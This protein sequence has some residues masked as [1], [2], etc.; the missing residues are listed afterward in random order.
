MS[1]CTFITSIGGTLLS[2]GIASSMAH[3]SDLSA[4]STQPI[5]ETGLST[6]LGSLLAIALLSQFWIIVKLL[7]TNRLLKTSKANLASNQ[8]YLATLLDSI[9]EGVIA[10]DLQ[11]H[12]TLINPAAEILTATAS[13]QALGTPLTDIFTL[14]DT[15]TRSPIPNPVETLQESQS[16]Q[17]L[18]P[19]IL[20]VS[21]NGKEHHITCSTAPIMNAEGA[22]QGTI[23]SFSDCTEK[24]CA[25]QALKESEHHLENLIRNLPGM[26]Y[27]SRNTPE[28]PM[29]F[30]SAGALDLTGYPPEAF[31]PA[32]E[33]KYFTLIHP[34]DRDQVWNEIQTAIQNETLFTLVYRLIDADHSEKWVW[35]Q[36]AAIPSDAP[37]NK[38]IEGFITDITLPKKTQD[39][40]N[41]SEERFKQLAD[42]LPEIIFETDL[43]GR[44]TF[45]NQI[46]FSMTGYTQEEFDKGLYAFDLVHP[47]D[48]ERARKNLK[49][50]F[51]TGPIG[52]TEY[53]LITKNGEEFH[54]MFHTLP[55]LSNGKPV[56]TRGY[57]ID[58]SSR[59]CT[60]KALQDERE[61]L[62]Q[63]FEYM[64]NGVAVYEPI[65]DANDFI[66]VDINKAGEHI[67]RVRK[68]AILGKRLTEVFPAAVEHGL[69]GALKR[70]NET[71]QPQY[72]PFS[73]YR[74]TRITQHI[75]NR[76]FRL[77][78]GR[79]VSLF[80]DRTQQRQLEDRLQ[81]MEKMDAVGQLAG[82]IAHDFNNQLGVILGYADM[83]SEV[84][85]DPVQNRYLSNIINCA[86][87]SADLTRKLLAFARKGKFQFVP[88]NLHT[89][90]QDVSDI[91]RHS[92]D[93]RITIKQHLSADHFYTQGDPS[94]LQNALL[95]LA[96]NARDAMPEG[97]S[98][99]FT[100]ANIQ[101]ES[102]HFESLHFE[103]E[104]GNYVMITVMDT[105][106]GIP[107]NYLKHIF[108]P[109]F[110]TKETGKGS[111]MGL[112]AVYGTIK[113]HKGAIDVIS[114][115]GQGTTFSLY[116]P[117]T[118]PDAPPTQLTEK[119]IPAQITAK[120][121][122]IE[123][124]KS[125]R[126]MLNDML[127]S[128]NC[129]AIFCD[130]GKQGIEEYRQNWQSIDLV[131]L[132]MVM[133]GMNGTETFRELVQINPDITIL[134]ISGYSVDGAAQQLLNEG[135]A[136]FIQKPFDK[137]Q[138]LEEIHRILNQKMER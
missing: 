51:E 48:R 14:L 13:Q 54:A 59:V 28:W 99:V 96:I 115:Q 86:H 84:I 94:Q 95:N 57:I 100:T 71:G 12:I 39:A 26:V 117:Q 112:A 125:V 134:L 106:S 77:P 21:K 41:E 35:E 83:L 130:T 25:Q 138:L 63:L 93:K 128:L 6:W 114:E 46:A 78:S 122:V 92:I 68:S 50:I 44:L 7:R 64:T 119:D 121:L 18:S 65:D 111:G 72:L 62:H 108:E 58:I 47:D 16:F 81:Q 109:F 45:A 70:A 40:L 66:F 5:S 129:S 73:E 33:I 30:V 126:S 135:A 3:A 61:H 53:R 34:D 56:G 137:N 104:A 69:L 36:G 116:L 89:V 88:V 76:I 38:I 52:Q 79:V 103:I 17:E 131:L 87:R 11:G 91:L 31:H 43:E 101:L 102:S 1:I 27:R 55:V 98:L 74:D 105:G 22:P 90:I 132:D 4:A 97:G 67:S 85:K 110:T 10:T 118:S 113:N 29:D 75:E 133:P 42:T 82:G 60:E 24:Y 136:G 37:D 80:D 32:G 19:P 49:A 123:D 127:F 20:L 124:E 120:L 107:E 23:I 9:G 8:A 15:A 2:L